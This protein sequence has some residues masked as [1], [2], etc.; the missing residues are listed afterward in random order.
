MPVTKY[1]GSVGD[2]TLRGEE[3]RGLI[4]NDLTAIATCLSCRQ[5]LRGGFPNDI[6]INREMNSIART[7]ISAGA[8]IS[9]QGLPYPQKQFWTRFCPP[10]AQ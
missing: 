5:S 10:A 8:I 7:N 4:S 6:P 1:D 9:Q 2:K 3:E